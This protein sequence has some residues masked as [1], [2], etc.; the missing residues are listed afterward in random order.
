MAVTYISPLTY[1]TNH[2][3]VE[4]RLF[5]EP[6]EGALKGSMISPRS[7]FQRLSTEGQKPLKTLYVTYSARS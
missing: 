2:G 4:Y 7:S 6:S 1:L 5:R 3:Y